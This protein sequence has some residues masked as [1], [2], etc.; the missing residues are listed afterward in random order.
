M[1]NQ[2]IDIINVR[3]KVFAAIAKMAFENK[4]INDL[5]KLIYD[6]APGETPQYRES[7]F[8]E[9][10]IIAERLRLALGLS[11]RSASECRPLVEGVQDIDINKR[12]YEAP[13][14]S[15]IPFAC[16]GCPTKTYFITENCRRC[17]AHPCL[18]VCPVNA[19]S[20][21]KNKME[22]DK[23]KCIKCGKCAEV[24]PYNSIIKYD[25]PCA[26]G[27]GVSAIESDELGR[28]VIN[29]DKCVSCGN[30][31]QE[32]P[33]GAIADK[34]QIYQLAK[35]LMSDENIVA[36]VAPA[37]VGQFG[38]LVS[39]A[40]IF[41]AIK[42]LG[43]S[44]VVEVGL[45]ADLGTLHEAEEFIHDVPKAVPFMGTSCCPSWYSMVEKNFP[46]Q[47]RCISDSST[48]ML[49]T[50]RYLKEKDEGAKVVFIGPCVAKKMES[51]NPKTKDNVDFVIT[52]EELVG[53]LVAKD[54]EPSE[55]EIEQDLFD[56]SNL[57]RGYAKAGGVAMAVKKTIEEIVPTLEVQID[58]ASGLGECVKLMRL[59][60]AGKRDGYLLEGM[61]CEGGCIAGPGTLVSLTRAEKALSEFQVQSPF[62]RPSENPVTK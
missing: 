57:G 21:G 33:F 10:A 32:C 56:A 31:I 25:R 60:K 45:G 18:V 6:I 44:D 19:V 35:A 43:F 14:V 52:F 22:I 15:V 37:F 39:P 29:N 55:I 4:S 27:C 47:L 62:Y 61:A 13:L 7:I 24:C 12:V 53:M 40:Q 58:S 48:P 1:R 2:Y 41:E 26:A 20:Y 16:D 42:K 36:I 59:A 9:R 38:P 46:D 8:L 34:S 11:V 50:A 30:C 51:I 28:A 5:G 17:L 3:R 54:I 49:A 23:G